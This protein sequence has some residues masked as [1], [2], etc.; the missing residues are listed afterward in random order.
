MGIRASKSY[1]ARDIKKALEA[2]GFTV[3]K[4]EPTG[5]NF[6]VTA[7]SSTGRK[8]TASCALDGKKCKAG[9][10]TGAHGLK[11]LSKSDLEKQ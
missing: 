8:S 6:L 3:A 5:K 1:S 7:T 10:L 11:D 2:L 4:C 9:G